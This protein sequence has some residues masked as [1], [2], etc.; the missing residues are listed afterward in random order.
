[1]FLLDNQ[2]NRITAAQTI[3][4]TILQRLAQSDKSAVQDCID[5]YGS[6]IWAFAKTKTTSLEEAEFLTLEIF[7]DIWKYAERF[8]LERCDETAFIAAI[9]HRRFIIH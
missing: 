3:N 8:D 6:L 1:M 9:A 7:K 5:K 4:R 2:T